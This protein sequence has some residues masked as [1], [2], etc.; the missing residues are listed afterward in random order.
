MPDLPPGLRP[1]SDYARER[2]SMTREQFLAA[3]AT[4][5][6]IVP[7]VAPL[8]DDEHFSTRKVPTASAMPAAE[9]APPPPP[10]PAW[11]AVKVQKRAGDAF[12][13]FIWVGREGKCDITLPFEGVSK[14]H[15]QFIRRGDG[16][17]ELLD[18]SSA[19]GTYLDGKRLE[20]NAP[21]AVRDGAK[22]QMGV[23]TMTYRTAEGFWDALAAFALGSP[24]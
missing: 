14:L 10:P 11:A 15:G 24:P 23:L 19:N 18:T 6:L 7:V 5:V 12:P 22:I 1:L 9:V 20:D 3:H 8:Q 2:Q 13:N 16:E 4:P 17:M 21:L